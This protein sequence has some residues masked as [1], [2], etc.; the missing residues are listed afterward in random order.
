M[1][2]EQQSKLLD[3]VEYYRKNHGFVDA[4]ENLL[5]CYAPRFR[6]RRDWRSRC[7]YDIRLRIINAFVWYK[8]AIS[9]LF[10]YNN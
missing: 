10:N 5:L 2:T 9:K 8:S 4:K 3:V 7:N 1:T 6:I